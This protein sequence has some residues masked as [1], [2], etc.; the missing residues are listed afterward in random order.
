MHEEM[1]H[2][3]VHLLTPDQAWAEAARMEDGVAASSF[4][5]LGL[6]HLARWRAAVA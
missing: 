1:E 6:L 2:I 5:S 4:L 3:R